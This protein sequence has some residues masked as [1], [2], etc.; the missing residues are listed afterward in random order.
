MVQLVLTLAALFGSAAC[1]SAFTGPM[2]TSSFTG[3]RVADN[4]ETVVAAPARRRSAVTPRMGGKEN[5]IRYVAFPCDRPC[6]CQP[7]AGFVNFRLETT[8]GCYVHLFPLFLRY[9][10]SRVFMLSRGCDGMVSF[11]IKVIWALTCLL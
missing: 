3:M 7:T 9:S 2:A 4:V 11:R 6:V 10:E 5:A 8:H 1:A